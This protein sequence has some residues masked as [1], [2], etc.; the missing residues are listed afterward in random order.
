MQ[1][2][3]QRPS[4]PQ[5]IVCAAQAAADFLKACGLVLGPMMEPEGAWEPGDARSLTA[6]VLRALE[7]V[8][9]DKVGG[10]IKLFT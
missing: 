4:I 2:C 10:V 6:K 8:K 5:T 3:Q 7:P 1:M 9:F